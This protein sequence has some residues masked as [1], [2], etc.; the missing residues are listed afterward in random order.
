MRS[1][2]IDVTGYKEAINVNIWVAVNVIT[3]S[4]VEPLSVLGG[5]QQPP[6]VNSIHLLWPL[7]VYS[8]ML[9]PYAIPFGSDHQ[10]VTDRCQ[11]WLG[12]TGGKW[13]LSA[14]NITL[15]LSDVSHEMKQTLQMRKQLRLIFHHKWCLRQ[16]SGFSPAAHDCI[17]LNCWRK[18]CQKHFLHNPGRCSQL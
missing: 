1:V 5:S 6:G 7:P 3:K 4:S 14:W 17:W 13:M 12:S 15:Q 8:Y 9:P 16:V 18:G 10:S 11:K 2:Q